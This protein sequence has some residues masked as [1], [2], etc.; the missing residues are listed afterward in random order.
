[1]SLVFSTCALLALVVVLS[2]AVLAQ[3]CTPLNDRCMGAVGMPAIPW[4]GCCEGSCVVDASK[5]WGSFCIADQSSGSS[6][7][8]NNQS[9]S[10]QPESEG[11]SS[12]PSS[13]TPN[14]SVATSTPGP[15][16]VPAP[17]RANVGGASGSETFHGRA[18]Y[19]GTPP[20]A[21][22][23]STACALENNMFGLRT[24]AMN[25][26]Q[27]DNS[28]GCGQCIRVYGSGVTCPG[29]VDPKDGSCGLG[30]N[31]ISG[32]FDA[33]VTDE[34]VERGTGDIDLGTAG[35]GYWPVSWHKIPCPSHTPAIV[36]HPGSNKYFAKI[37]FRY[38]DSPFVSMELNG[39]PADYRY[40]DNYMVFSAQ[41]GDGIPFVGGKWSLTATS[42]LGTKYCG[43]IDSSFNPRPFEYPAR[44]C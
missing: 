15:S 10:V 38:I 37:Q 29:G 20:M 22:Q 4:L 25:K 41:A 1:M 42:S 26:V 27:F 8:T 40:S 9:P 17:V 28:K 13:T 32:T 43:E 24:V 12:A 30:A 39:K 21:G 34:L 6:S 19:Y 36:L 14:A 2:D 44:K 33:V 3:E 35:D 31:P 11:S 7:G 18:T 16:P 5:G 23:P